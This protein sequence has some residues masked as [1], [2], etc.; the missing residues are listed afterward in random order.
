MRIKL[1]Y[2]ERLWKEEQCRTMCRISRHELYDIQWGI[3]SFFKKWLCFN[4]I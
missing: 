2:K 3:N 1:N 4:N